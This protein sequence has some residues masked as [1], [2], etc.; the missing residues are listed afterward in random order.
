MPGTHRAKIYELLMFPFGL[1]CLV[2][3]FIPKR[4]IIP[5]LRIAVVFS[6]FLFPDELNQNVVAQEKVVMTNKSK[7]TGCRQCA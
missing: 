7:A 1:G 4:L 6:A 5:V 2:T 3:A